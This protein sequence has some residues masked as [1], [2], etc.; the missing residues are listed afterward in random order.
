M[1]PMNVKFIKMLQDVVYNDTNILSE[2]A[3]LRSSDH[4]FGVDVV[5]HV[6]KEHVDQQLPHG[7]RVKVFDKIGKNQFVVTISDNPKVIKSKSFL[8]S[9]ELNKL[10]KGIALYKIPFLN[11]WY[12]ITYVSEDM[13][14]DMRLIDE[15]NIAD[16]EIR[17]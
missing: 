3:N 11:F 14:I 9:K 4:K 2:M 16:V 15:G 17:Y 7:P 10:L 12:D 13:K 5:L 6:Y 8:S 1:K